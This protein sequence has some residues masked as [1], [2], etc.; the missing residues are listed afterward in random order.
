MFAAVLLAGVALLP[1]GCKRSAAKN[2]GE[3]VLS[4]NIEVTDAQ[5]GFK[6]P[7]RVIERT[8]SEGERVTVGQLVARLDDAEQGHELALRRAELAATEA[9]LAELQAGSRPQE[10]AAA[11]AA[12]RSAEAERDRA[13][14]EFTRQKELLARNAISSREFESAQAQVKVAEARAGEM[15]ER[16]KLIKEGPRQETIRHA[17]ARRQQAVAAVGLAQTRLDYTRL[18]SPLAGVVLAHHIEPGEFVTAGT[19]VISVAELTRIWVRVY[20]NQTDLARIRHGQK[21]T[22]RT[23]SSPEKTYEGIVGFIAS[24]AEFTPKTVQTPRER[25]KLVF[26][27]K[28]DLANPDGAL[29]PGM[30]ADVVIAK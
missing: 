24:E 3:L 25:V 15:L 21:V 8:V 18:F 19:P 17:E 27:V 7:G 4:G 29:K 6:L 2:D 9:V 23:D 10:I 5:L 26:R 11:E 20:I 12:M 13:T 14:L 28:V 30:P 1:S 22:V 16:V